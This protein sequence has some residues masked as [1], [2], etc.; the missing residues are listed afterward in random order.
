MPNVTI[1]TFIEP[2][3]ITGEVFVTGMKVKNTQDQSEETI[4]CGGVFVEI[5]QIPNTGYV[6]D[7]VETNEIGTI[8]IDPWTQATSCN[9]IWAAGDCTNIHYHQNNIAAGDAVKALEDIY[10]TLKAR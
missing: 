4:P 3:E 2:T 5:G 1:K 10:M 7:L 6:K 9:G 8:R